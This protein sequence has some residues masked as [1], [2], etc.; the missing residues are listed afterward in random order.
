MCLSVRLL[1]CVSVC[2]FLAICQ[3]MQSCQTLVMVLPR[4]FLCVSVCCAYVSQQKAF[5]CL[6]STELCAHLARHETPSGLTPLYPLAFH[7]HCSS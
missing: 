5:T 6:E 4:V 7:F 1:A 2:L 3:G